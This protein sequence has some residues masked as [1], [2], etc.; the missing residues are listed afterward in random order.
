MRSAA[1]GRRMGVDHPSPAAPGLDA[2]SVPSLHPLD[3]VLL[4][5]LHP[6]VAQ[7]VGIHWADKTVNALSAYD[8]LIVAD[9][10]NVAPEDGGSA[11][12]ARSATDAR[13]SC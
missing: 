12:T 4:G 3:L 8:Y 7:M 9:H 2:P 10:R 5:S 6:A 11:H 1:C 13:L